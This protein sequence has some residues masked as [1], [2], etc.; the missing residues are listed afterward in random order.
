MT[1]IAS[2]LP[3]AVDID[4]WRPAPHAMRALNR[5]APPVYATTPDL[6]EHG[7]AH[8]VRI[9]ARRVVDET[10][11]ETE[12]LE[13]EQ[14]GPVRGRVRATKATTPG[15]APPSTAPCANQATARRVR[16]GPPTG[17]RRVGRMAPTGGF[18]DEHGPERLV[19]LSDGVFAIAMTLLVLDISVPPDLG[20]AGFRHALGELPPKIAAYALSFLIIGAFWLDHRRALL[21]MRSVDLPFTAVTLAGL[22]VT[23]FVPFPTSLLSEYGSMP[24]SIAIYAATIA[25][26]DLTQIALVLLRARHPERDR[27]PLPPALA[28]AWII[29]LATTVVVFLVTIP[30]AWPLGGD[31][32]W[33]WL[34]LIPLKGATGRSRTAASRKTPE[35]DSR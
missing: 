7:P 27:T 35:T 22:G 19:A 3:Q 34:V 12:C 24:A 17:S 18:G 26:M 29:D 9:R 21:G 14:P 32:M 4:R 8:R 16:R 10:V 30:L 6:A 31:A 25:A 1:T 11:G 15:S 13:Q 23:A 5:T 20:A 2:L 28:R 33:L